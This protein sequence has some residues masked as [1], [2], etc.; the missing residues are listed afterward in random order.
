MTTTIHTGPAGSSGPHSADAVRAWCWA[1]WAAETHRW[2][3]FPLEPYDK[4]PMTG[5]GGHR[6]AWS[7]AATNDP[8]VIARARCRGTATGYGIDA[9][10]SGLVILDMDVPEPGEDHLAPEW[11]N[12][13]GI[14]DG[15]DVFAALMERAGEQHWPDTFTVRTPSGGLQLYYEAL[16]DRAIGN[17][18]LGPLVDVRGGGQGNGG[19]VCG[20]GSV[21]DERAYLPR[22]PWK[23][24]LVRGGKAYVI[25]R[26]IR[27][28][29]LPGWIAD[30]LDPPERPEPAGGPPP[31]AEGLAPG[32]VR[33]A[34]EGELANVIGAPRARGNQV[35]NDA[36]LKLGRFV[37]AGQLPRGQV[38]DMLDRRR[39]ARRP[40]RRSR[41]HRHHPVRAGRGSQACRMTADPRTAAREILDSH[42]PPEPGGLTGQHAG[43]RAAPD[44][45]RLA[46]IAVAYTPVDWAVA[47][48][49]QPGA[50]EWLLEPLLEAGTV[51]AL[52]GKPGAGK[53]LITLEIALRLVRTGHVI[54]YVDQENRIRD[55]VERLQAFGAGPDELGRLLMYSFAGLPP[56]DTAEGGEHLLAL[57]V[58]ACAD[59]VVLDTTSRMVRGKENEADTFLNLYRCALV[60]LKGRGI[61]V[62]RLDHP[63][64][65]ESRGQRGSSAK[66]GDVDTIWRLVQAGPAAFRLER[67][68]TRNGHGDPAV[69]LHRRFGP[70]RHEWDVRSDSPE[71]R[72]AG[73]LDT[74]G[75]PI[76]AGR[77]AARKALET[78][79]TKVS[80]TQLE[81]ALRLRKNGQSGSGQ[82][83]RTSTG[84]QLPADWPDD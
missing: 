67:E 12:E 65:D 19:Y 18:P 23:A 38:E 53:S 79:G 50:V 77:P 52:F 34:V 64:K 22:K 26:N 48:K 68:K 16:P 44:E 36:A 60:P 40:A 17:R 15:T 46:E 63:G 3:V 74:L 73:Q 29:P 35:L 76:G 69:T 25:A 57:A 7:K 33:A 27:P 28:V 56:L 31:S 47:W 30:L 39:D 81:A 55:L 8:D 66:D 42:L 41:D 62:L 72:I 58:S 2:H 24:S 37:A 5:P 70:L 20:P 45:A 82:N 21:I 9:K 75:V 6:I 13:P 54:V 84:D 14:V 61:T 80:N 32:Y 51:N 59:L 78:A 4:T 10:K 1:R 49:D 71:A 43:S 11:R 83:K